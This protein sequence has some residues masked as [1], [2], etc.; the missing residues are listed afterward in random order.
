MQKLRPRDFEDALSV[1]ERF[2]EKLDRKYLRKWT[3]RLRVTAELDYV[4]AL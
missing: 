3:A 4:M 2:R 1:V